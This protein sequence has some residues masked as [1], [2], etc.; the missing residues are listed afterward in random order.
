MSADQLPAAVQQ[1]LDSLRV[2]LRRT[3]ALRGLG[4]CLLDSG[5]FAFAALAADFLLDLE[6]STRHGCWRG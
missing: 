5:R 3:A 6:S 4:Y 1:E 2:H